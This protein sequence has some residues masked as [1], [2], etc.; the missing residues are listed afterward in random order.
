M[1]RRQFATT[2]EL[3]ETEDGFTEVGG[4]IFPFGETAH[5]RESGLDGE[6]EE[7]DE[8][9]VP[10]CTTKIRQAAAKRGGSPSWISYTVDHDPT[11][12]GRIGYCTG[13]V[14]GDDGAYATF[15]LHRDPRRIDKIRSMLATSHNGFSIGFDDWPAPLTGAL[16]RHRQITIGEVTAT[17]IPVYATAG[18]MAVRAGEDPLDIGTPRLDAVRAMIEAWKPAGESATT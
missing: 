8:E 11:M 18:I 15:R 5:I 1:M 7:Y 2:V 17:A 16:R 3:T 9:F 13:L 6:I 14:E 4:R 10:G 12:D